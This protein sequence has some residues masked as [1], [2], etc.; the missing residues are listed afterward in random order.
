MSAAAHLVAVPA[1]ELMTPA[2]VARW[3]KVSRSMAYS[4]MRTKLR[5]IYVGRLPRVW[6]SEVDRYLQSLVGIPR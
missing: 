5:P 1:D 4:L 6:R 2:E 3:L